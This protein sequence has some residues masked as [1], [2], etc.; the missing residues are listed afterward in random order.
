MCAAVCSKWRKATREAITS[1]EVRRCTQEKCDELQQW[2]VHPPTA[3]HSFA[4][5]LS[6]CELQPG[7]RLQLSVLHNLRDLELHSVRLEALAADGSVLQ[8]ADLL[9]Q[10][11][12]CTKLYFVACYEDEHFSAAIAAVKDMPALQDLDLECHA[13]PPGVDLATLP[14]TLTR[15]GLTGAP[16]INS[17]SAAGFSQLTGLRV[18]DASAFGCDTSKA[19][20]G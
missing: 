1:I 16:C 17:T 2:L 11:Q 12:H 3:L 15:L 6:D 18:L 5:A 4:L 14:T 10:L 20:G 19:G 13:L 9:P 7:L 8:V